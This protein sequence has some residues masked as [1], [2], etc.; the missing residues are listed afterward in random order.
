MPVRKQVFFPIPM[1]AKN[2]VVEN[3][4]FKKFDELI[5]KISC[6]ESLDC[7]GHIFRILS[8]WQS[9]LNNL[10]TPT[11]E[12]PS[13]PGKLLLLPKLPNGS[14]LTH[15]S[16][17]PGDVECLNF[18]TWGYGLC[19]KCSAGSKLYSKTMIGLQATKRWGF[20]R[21]RKNCSAPGLQPPPLW[22]SAN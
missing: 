2:R 1:V 7:A 9:C 6:H 21:H 12:K 15:C 11:K 5:G 4:L 22:D 3:D 20:E 17:S 10:W 18:N 13:A 16:P 14:K 8:L 19:S